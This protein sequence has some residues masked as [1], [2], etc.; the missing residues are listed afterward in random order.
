MVA[1]A[2]AATRAAEEAAAADPPPSVLASLMGSGTAEVSFRSLYKAS[3]WKKLNLLPRVSQIFRNKMD[4]LLQ[5]YGCGN[6]PNMKEEKEE[7]P[8][9]S[10]PGTS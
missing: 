2:R 3:E 6:S 5:I 10:P 8:F 4:K 9:L 1:A 7:L